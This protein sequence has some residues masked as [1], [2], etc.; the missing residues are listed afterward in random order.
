MDITFYALL[1]VACLVLVLAMWVCAAQS[2]PKWG[3]DLT[4]E[5]PPHLLQEA[6]FP[7][8]TTSTNNTIPVRIHPVPSA[9]SELPCDP[10]LR[11]EHSMGMSSPPPLPP[12]PPVRRAPPPP[13]LLHMEHPVQVLPSHYMPR[14]KLRP[15]FSTFTAEEP[16]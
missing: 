8:A 14:N 10:L 4:L 9:P 2:T 7:A 1:T 3:P 15:V 13:V 12:K 16:A 11:N 6:L 5:L